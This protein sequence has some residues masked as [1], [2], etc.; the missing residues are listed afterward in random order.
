M[1]VSKKTRQD[2]SKH[3]LNKYTIKPV[4]RPPLNRGHPVKKGECLR[5]LQ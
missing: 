5:D 2:V 3:V 4:L 1:K